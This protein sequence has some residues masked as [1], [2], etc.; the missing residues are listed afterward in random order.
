MRPPCPCRAVLRAWA[1]A[2]TPLLDRLWL[3][4]LTAADG[5]SGR[6]NLER[7]ASEDVDET[8]VLRLA[9]QRVHANMRVSTPTD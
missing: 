4:A 3:L 7:A 6:S 1:A 2:P 9:N 5:S 8:E